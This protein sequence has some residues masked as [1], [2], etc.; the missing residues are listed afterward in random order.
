MIYFISFYGAVTVAAAFQA[1]FFWLWQLTGNWKI[2]F[3]SLVWAKYSI[4]GFALINYFHKMIILVR[5]DCLAKTWLEFL[6]SWTFSHFY[7]GSNESLEGNGMLIVVYIQVFNNWIP[8]IITIK[9]SSTCLG[10][11]PISAQQFFSPLTHTHGT[12]HSILFKVCNTNNTFS[13]DLYSHLKCITMLGGIRK[14][15]FIWGH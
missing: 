11:F 4:P 9:N 6:L 13:I 12:A 1:I 2:E 8:K 14:N 5:T 3:Q 10:S 15:L 7:N